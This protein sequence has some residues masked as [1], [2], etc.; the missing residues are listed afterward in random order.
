[1]YCGKMIAQSDLGKGT[2]FS[3]ADRVSVIVGFRP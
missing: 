1:M 3:R 2:T